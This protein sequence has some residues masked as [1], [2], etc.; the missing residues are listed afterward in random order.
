MDVYKIK[1]NFFMY[2]TALKRDITFVQEE[3]FSVNA[4]GHSVKGP[5]I[6]VKRV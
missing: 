1:W 2:N 6:L 4:M 3:D 5:T